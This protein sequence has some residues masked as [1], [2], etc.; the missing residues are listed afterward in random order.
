MEYSPYLRE[1][2][3]NQVFFGDTHLHTAFS[4]DAGL[5]MA[6]TTP[7]DAYRFA[8][9]EEVISSQGIPARLQ[10]PLDF[11]V[12]ADHSE[13]LGIAI[14]L[15]EENPILD[16]NEWGRTLA[17]TYAPKTID[18]RNETYVQWFG[19]VN[20]AGGSDPMKGSGLDETMWKRITKAAERHNEP[21]SF[22]AFIG[23]E[24]TSGPNGNNL[25]RNV[26][27]RDG[28]ELADQIVPFSTYDS[29]DPEDLWQWMADYEEKTGGRLL[30]IPHNGNLSNGLMFDD[31][32]L[33]G[34]PLTA[35]YAER[36]Q[37]WEPI[38]EVTQIKGDGEAHPMLSPND[39]FA[40]YYTWDKGSFGEEP[41]T[42][43]MLPREYARSAWKRGMA[44]EAELGV[45]P[46]KMGVVGSTDSH[47][48]LSTAQENNFFGKVTLVEPTADPIRFE[49]Q[50]TGRFTP[51]DPSDDQIVGDGLAAGI[52]AVWARENTREAI[53]D[54]M[55]RKETFATTGTRMRVR[56]FAGWDFE[57]SDLQRSNFAAYGYDNGVPMGGD[58]TA[59][60][61]SGAPTLLVRALRDPDGANL[62]RVQIIKGWT[63]ADGEPKEKVY[64]VAWS[65]DRQPGAD[66]KL[67]PVGNTVDVEKAEYSNSIGDPFLQA[68]WKDP[69][70]DAS[71]RAFYYVR[72][73]EIPT[74]SWLTYDSAFFGVEI[75]EG[76]RKTQQER[77][78]T[79]PIWYTPQG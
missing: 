10:R 2:F 15:E 61:D 79:S 75:P 36:R 1:D 33:S 56:V 17:E 39:E 27:F 21:G 6:T 78:Y 67:P 71:Q 51:D 34:E 59:A 30:A 72:V 70:F 23:Y 50:I 65:D 26:I 74:P 63:T 38:Y 66:G 29:D 32:T 31:V 58:L 12:V 14:A 7:D 41:K 73:L 4:A 54:A 69:D 11:L 28:K 24:W 19:A 47:T 76:K 48:G 64:D 22:T 49:E 35:D 45:N 13:N 42:E 60:P 40:D 68:F 44:Y 52:A 37:R 25:H 5:A 62:D 3:P 46:F 9:G 57:E 8:K 53:W 43:D 77:A 20:T 18:A 55:K 16:S